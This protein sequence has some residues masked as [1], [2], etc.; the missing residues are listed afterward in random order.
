MRTDS[1]QI[2][3][4]GRGPQLSTSRIT[5]LDV[6]YYLHRGYDFDRM[7]QAMP[8]LS[9]EEFDV[10]A[11]YVKEH[12]DELVEKDRRAE[13][14]IQRGLAEQ[15]AKGLYQEIDE[16]VPL[17]ERVARL[18]AKT[19]QRLELANRLFREYHTRSFWHC[20]PDLVITEELIPM[21]VQGLR[22]YGGR[23]GFILSRKLR[24]REVACPTNDGESQECP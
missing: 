15:K 8:S 19:R 3:D 23:E 11:E 7:R 2:V 22:K 21:V 10:V 18:K 9:R 16:S 17:E 12:H 4:R 24:S 14:F 20:P 6:F 5:V 1:I 13:E